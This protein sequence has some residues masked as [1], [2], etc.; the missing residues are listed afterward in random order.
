MAWSLSSLPVQRKK[1]ANPFKLLEVNMLPLKGTDK[2]SK[3][4]FGFVH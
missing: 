1:L 4:P 3:I 2:Q